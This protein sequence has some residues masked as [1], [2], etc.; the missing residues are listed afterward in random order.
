MS[1]DQRLTEKQH[2]IFGI[3]LQRMRNK[4]GDIAYAL[5]RAY[6]RKIVELADAAQNAV[7]A[8]RREL[9]ERAALESPGTNALRSQY[10]RGND[11]MDDIKRKLEHTKY[12]MALP[13]DFDRL[14]REG[15]LFR[16]G[17]K[18]IAPDLNRLPEQVLQRIQ[19]IETEGNETVLTL[20]TRGI[21]PE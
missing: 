20:N 10:I 12:L 8:L 9:A 17:G 14:E 18:F 15:V 1:Q 5:G 11:V 19:F 7:D 16:A 2:E 4:L 6:P 3:E 13:I 21:E